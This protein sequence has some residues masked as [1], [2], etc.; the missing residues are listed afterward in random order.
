MPHDESDRAAVEQVLSRFGNPCG[1]A[2]GYVAVRL[3]RG[4]GELADVVRALDAD[5]LQ[6][7]QL[8]LHEPSLDDVFLAKTGRLLEGA[9]DPEEEPVPA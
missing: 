4:N 8:Q 1:G 7:A 3:D 2:P 9:A 5:D 6:V